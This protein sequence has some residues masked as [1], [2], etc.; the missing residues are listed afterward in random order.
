[1][2]ESALQCIRPA[3]SSTGSSNV[4][5]ASADSGYM[6][7]RLQVPFMFKYAVDGLTMC[8]ELR[9]ATFAKVLLTCWHDWAASL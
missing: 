6:H 9:N 1:V 8:N 4:C 7:V 3:A 5:A 2:R